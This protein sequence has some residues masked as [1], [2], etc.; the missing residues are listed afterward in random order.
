MI[1]RTILLYWLLALNCNTL[2]SSAYIFVEDTGSIGSLKGLLKEN[3]NNNDIEILGYT[4]QSLNVVFNKTNKLQTSMVWILRESFESEA[5]I[6]S[7]C[8]QAEHNQYI[9]GLITTFKNRVSKIPRLYMGWIPYKHLGQITSQCVLLEVPQT[10]DLAP[11][12][13][14]LSE[15]FSSQSEESE[16][17]IPNPSLVKNTESLPEKNEIQQ[18][19]KIPMQWGEFKKMVSSESSQAASYAMQKISYDPDED[20]FLTPFVN[21]ALENTNQAKNEKLNLVDK[22]NSPSSKS[23][24]KIDTST[25]TTTDLTRSN[26]AFNM[27]LES[28][29]KIFV[30]S[31]T[32][33]FPS[34]SMKSSTEK[35]TGTSPI[36]ESNRS[37]ISSSITVPSIPK[38]ETS[39][40]LNSGISSNMSSLKALYLSTSTTPPKKLQSTVQEKNTTGNPPKFSEQKLLTGKLKKQN[41][42][43]KNLIKELRTDFRKELLDKFRKERGR[44]APEWLFEE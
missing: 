19:K 32:L 26:T 8:G 13:M 42:K 1:Y 37:S 6:L 41:S 16:I 35:M 22:A 27:K 38:S 40:T 39:T 43:N 7:H 25:K 20:L 24:L 44:Q 12:A 21:V 34:I 18:S 15:L 5:F 11:L 3:L 28:D 10:Y 30:S 14:E 36:I 33:N 9:D 17:D 2:W 4:S 29:Q 31:A 23:S